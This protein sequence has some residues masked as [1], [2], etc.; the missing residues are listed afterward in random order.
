MGYDDEYT[1]NSSRRVSCWKDSSSNS[2]MLLL[3]ISLRE[4][5]ENTYF[6]RYRRIYSPLLKNYTHRLFFFAKIAFSPAFQRAVD[7]VQSG[8]NNSYFHSFCTKFYPLPRRYFWNVVMNLMSV[9]NKH[10]SIH[11]SEIRKKLSLIHFVIFSHDC[12]RDSSIILLWSDTSLKIPSTGMVETN[13][14]IFFLFSRSFW[15][16]IFSKIWVK[17]NFTVLLT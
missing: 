6:K 13:S 4:K 5:N 10:R 14:L 3:V 11:Q 17:I 16:L 2:E 7:R 9:K 1:Y 15:R 12:Q 8:Q